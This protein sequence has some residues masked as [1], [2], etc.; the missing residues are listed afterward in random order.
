MNGVWF[1]LPNISGCLVL[2]SLKAF[3]TLAEKL[4][5]VPYAEQLDWKLKTVRLSGHISPSQ[6]E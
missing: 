1:L 6:I 2:L 5:Q 3:P 4:G